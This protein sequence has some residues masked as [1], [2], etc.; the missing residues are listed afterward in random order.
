MSQWLNRD[1]SG[2]S[3]LSSGACADNVK[4]CHISLSLLSPFLLLFLPTCLLTCD[5]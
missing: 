5:L 4:L 3:H 2:V 1:E